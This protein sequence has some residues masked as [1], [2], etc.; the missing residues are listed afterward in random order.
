MKFTLPEIPDGREQSSR[1]TS[2]YDAL[3]SKLGKKL[4]ASA[5]ATAKTDTAQSGTDK[6]ASS[7]ADEPQGR[8]PFARAYNGYEVDI[9]Q[10]R[11]AGEGMPEPVKGLAT[12]LATLISWLMVP[13]LMPVV[14]CILML[15]VSV[16]RQ[17][18]GDRRLAIIMVVAGL[19][20]LLPMILIAVLRALGVVR[21]I[22]LNSRRERLAPYIITILGLGCTV[23]FLRMQGAPEWMW[24]TFLGAA[25]ATAI[26]CLV[27]F[28]WKISA[29]ATGAAG[30][31]AALVAMG[32]WGQAPHI[33]WWLFGACLLTGLMGSA[34]VFL[35]RH[36]DLQVL[37]GYV[38]GFCSVY[39][40]ILILCH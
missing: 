39:F 21:D 6:P 14:S 12:R 32:V 1:D 26:C 31:I 15:G 40:T 35:R 33:A 34:R 17:L 19:N 18:P 8:Q 10:A 23:V 27:N 11:E 29:H 9:A 13:L 36:T 24:G 3:L 20:T 37:A 38:V 2:H 16:Y 30:V 5:D 4:Q 25:V 7:V 28:W 22:G